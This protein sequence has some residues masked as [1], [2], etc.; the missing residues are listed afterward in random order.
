MAVGD[1][2]ILTLNCRGLCDGKKRLRVFHFLQQQQ[3]DIALLQETY[4]TKVNREKFD[5][6]WAGK[7]IHSE[8]DSSHS[9]GVAILIRSGIDATV[10]KCYRGEEGRK[11]IANVDI[12]GE[13]LTIVSA[14]APNKVGQR[15]DFL[16]RL[17][18]C[19]RQ[20][21]TNPD[22]I[23]IGADL[24]VA[25]SEIDRTKPFVDRSVEQLRKMKRE[26]N[27]QDLFRRIYPNK[28]DYTF[29]DP[30][31]NGTMSRI[32]YILASEPL[33]GKVKQVK[34]KSAPVPDHRAV[35]AVIDLKS[36]P[37]GRGYWK[38][39]YSVLHD[40]YYRLQVKQIIRETISQFERKTSYANV[41]DLCKIRIKEFSILFGI[42][43]SRERKNKE[44]SL[45]NKLQQLDQQLVQNFNIDVYKQRNEIQQ[46]LD[47][48]LLNKAKGAQIRSR[49][50][51]VEFGERNNA[52]FLNLEKHRQS[53]N[54]IE[55]LNVP[56]G[57]I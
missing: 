1:L 33:L 2:K 47:N 3:I 56:G 30:S 35:S 31:G 45:G 51:W 34:I 6:D 38:L 52:Y 7:V 22:K 15:I 8:S 43:E 53:N 28:R 20:N 55:K 27:M 11:V 24:N 5:H 23:I 9:R 25:D 37:R 49:A 40:D 41:W 26:L 19:V 48:A 29:I 44:N 13:I 14:Y 50:N 32:D 16:K 39:N 21:S 42:N 4:V 57:T 17:C 46:E 54:M 12:N 36:R 10:V 18:K